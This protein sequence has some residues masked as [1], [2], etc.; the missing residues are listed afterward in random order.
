MDSKPKFE[1]ESVFGIIGATEKVNK[2]LCL[3]S[4]N[5]RTPVYDLRAWSIYN[6]PFKGVTMNGEELRELRKILNEM[7]LGGDDDV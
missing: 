2:K 7:D 3:V 5:S 6:E 1:I 4:W